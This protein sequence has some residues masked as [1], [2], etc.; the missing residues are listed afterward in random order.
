MAAL[1]AAAS[2]GATRS[3]FYSIKEIWTWVKSKVMGWIFATKRIA[4]GTRSFLGMTRLVSSHSH[5]LPDSADIEI[6]VNDPTG[7]RALIFTG[8][9]PGKKVKFDFGRVPITVTTTP[10]GFCGIGGYVITYRK[11]KAI[12]FRTAMRELYTRVE[13]DT[14]SISQALPAEGRP[15]PDGRVSDHED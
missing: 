15:S 6:N 2:V 13:Y 1:I 14:T 7:P 9:S 10:G 8:P 5:D 11:T 4:A 3:L 12:D